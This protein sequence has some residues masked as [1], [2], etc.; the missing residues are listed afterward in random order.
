MK[1]FTGFRF[2]VMILDDA[3]TNPEELKQWVEEAIVI[4]VEARHVKVV[5][6]EIKEDYLASPDC[7]FAEA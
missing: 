3:N 4:H 5:L 2:D 1:L 6:K 7:E